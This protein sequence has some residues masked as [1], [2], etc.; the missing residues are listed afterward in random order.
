MNWWRRRDNVREELDNLPQWEHDY[1]LVETSQQGLFYEYLEMGKWIFNWN[2]LHWP[3][4]W[5]ILLKMTQI[6]TQVR[7]IV[8]TIPLNIPPMCEND[9]QTH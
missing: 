9:N 2:P 8:K 4:Q 5:K 6:S 1:D 3:P 7:K